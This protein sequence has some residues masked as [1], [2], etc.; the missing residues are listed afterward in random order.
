ME[1]MEETTILTKVYILLP[2]CAELKYEKKQ[3]YDVFLKILKNVIGR[4]KLD[5]DAIDN[6][7]KLGMRGDEFSINEKD[8]SENWPILKSFK[9]QKRLTKLLGYWASN[10]FPS[11]GK[12][13]FERS[14]TPPKRRSLKVNG[15]SNEISADQI[16]AFVSQKLDIRLIEL[17]VS[18]STLAKV[19]HFVNCPANI[20]TKNELQ[21]SDKVKSFDVDDEWKEECWRALKLGSFSLDGKSEVSFFL[22]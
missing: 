15:R 13:L 18:Q 4:S 12:K 17:S 11:L 2:I 9:V 20:G 7:F 3:E 1:G 21:I 16:D 6:A 14:W 22:N 10:N 8:L 5:K 19:R